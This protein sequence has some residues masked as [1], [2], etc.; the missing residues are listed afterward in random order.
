H[1]V[2]DLLDAIDLDAAPLGEGGL[3][4]TGRNPDPQAAGDE[5]QQCPAP[6]RVERV[7]P[8][9][10]QE[11]HPAAARFFQPLDDL[12]KARYMP[13]GV[14]RLGPDQ[15]YGLGEIAD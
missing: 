13:A 7:E 15:R 9:L 5:L 2:P 4:E 10:E 6:G 8:W 1:P 14:W 3:G 12:G 11:R